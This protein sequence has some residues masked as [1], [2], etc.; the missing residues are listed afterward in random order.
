MRG[1]HSG[2]CGKPPF[3]FKEKGRL[4]FQKKEIFWVRKPANKF[5]FNQ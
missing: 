2:Y 3:S 5:P 1:S 4:R